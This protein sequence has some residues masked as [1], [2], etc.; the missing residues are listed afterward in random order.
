MF[1]KKRTAEFLCFSMVGLG[2]TAVDFIGFFILTFS[3]IPYL[4]AQ[5]LA[6]SAGMVNSY[7]MN[8]RW[9]F[10]LTCYGDLP[11]MVRFIT[12]NLISLGLSSALLFL[13]HDVGNL[14]L[15]PSKFIATGSGLLV[16][17]TGT[18]LWVFTPKHMTREIR[19]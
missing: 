13:A 4:G 17:Y 18:Q 11:E 5:V 9:T 14:A 3:G 16:N 10:H 8:R 7:L 19:H 15:W 6:Y 1:N 2:N 12:I